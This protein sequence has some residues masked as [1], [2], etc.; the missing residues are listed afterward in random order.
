MIKDIH[1]L[2]AFS[3]TELDPKLMLEFYE[4]LTQIFWVA[5]NYLLHAYCLEKFYELSAKA[6]V[7]EAKLQT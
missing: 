3:T 2:M 4:R 5:E 1:E 7:D 6:K